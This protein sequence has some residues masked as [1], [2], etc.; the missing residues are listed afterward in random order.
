[1]WQPFQ[2]WTSTCRKSSLSLRRHHRRPVASPPKS[3]W[4]ITSCDHVTQEAKDAQQEMPSSAPTC[5]SIFLHSSPPSAL[6]CCLN[7]DFFSCF[8]FLFVFLKCSLAHYPLIFFFFYLPLKDFFCKDSNFCTPSPPYPH[9][10]P[11][12]QF[13]PLSLTHTHTQTHIQYTHICTHMH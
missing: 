10:T 1:M 2:N 8:F 6:P 12:L 5:I 4:L 3:L 7:V 11:G 9:K 13:S